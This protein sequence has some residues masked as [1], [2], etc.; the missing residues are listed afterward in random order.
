MGWS[1]CC[2]LGMPHCIKARALVGDIYIWDLEGALDSM[3]IGSPVKDFRTT[4]LDNADNFI[5]LIAVR[6]PLG[7]TKTLNKLTFLL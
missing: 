6:T 7:H 1:D 3:N 5:T 2:S 4:L